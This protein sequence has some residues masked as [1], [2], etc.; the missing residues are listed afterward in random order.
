VGEEAEE[1]G[2]FRREGKFL[3]VGGVL[4]RG[5]VEDGIAPVAGAVGEEER[6]LGKAA[7]VLVG[8]V[9][10]ADA[11]DGLRLLE[12]DDEFVWVGGLDGTP[13]GV[14]EGVGVAVDRL[15]GFVA[16][17]FAVG[18]GD[19][20]E[21]LGDRENLGGLGGGEGEGGVEVARPCVREQ[22]RERDRELRTSGDGEGRGAAQSAR[23]VAR[24]SW[25]AGRV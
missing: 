10:E 1:A 12:L 23:P 17:G 2:V 5:V 6:D 9:L 3:P 16:G 25:G 21:G 22:A 7:V 20:V 18:A 15:G 24:S 14:P 13:A 4:E 19:G 11:L 8:P